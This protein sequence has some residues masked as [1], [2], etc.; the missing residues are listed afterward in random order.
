MLIRS[1][2]TFHTLLLSL[3]HLLVDGIC[4]CGM[5]MMTW[6][7]VSDVEAGSLI[8]IYDVLA[9][10][11][12][13][14]T[15]RWLDTSGASPNRLKLAIAL[16]VG[17]ASI[18][19]LPL[20][21]NLLT[22]MT[23]TIMFGMGNSLFHVYGGKI[24]AVA[25]HYDIRMM[26]VFVS[27]GAVGLAIG[28][29][30]FCPM[31]MTAFLLALIA[32]SALHLHYA[33]IVREGKSISFYTENVVRP[34]ARSLPIVPL[35]YLSCLMLVVSGR[36]FIGESVPSLRTVFHSMGT[37]MTMVVVS[38]IVMAGKAAGGFLS[39]MWGVRNVFYV[40]MLLSA[41]TFLMCPW[42][43]VFVLTT[44]LLINISMPCT[45]YLATKAVPGREGWTFGLLA[46]ALLPG[47]MLGHLAKDNATCQMLLE[48]LMATIL[49]ESLLLLCM[50][51]HRWQVL[52]ASVMLNIFTNVP[53]NAFIM[54]FKVTSPFYLVG[55]ECVVVVVEFI[56][57]WLVLYDR[58]RAFKY[59]FLCNSFSALTGCLYQYLF[60]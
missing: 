23:A 56:G 14:L 19:L 10:A 54:F 58:C 34:T 38:I 60:L 43:D 33:G 31:L 6:Q 21:E 59:S 47:F 28:I 18:S 9:F 49:L 4:A 17:G 53:L 3:L 20:S 46:M 39:K 50:R 22:A 55:L 40:S 32:L 2:I 8:V 36:S 15:G 11:T 5:M 45:L 41:T 12:Q 52:A 37:P 51:E 57:Y 30:F 35:L 44:L 24:V 1:S 13:P 42:H 27:T 29:G 48:P 25:S 7:I 16:L 26:G